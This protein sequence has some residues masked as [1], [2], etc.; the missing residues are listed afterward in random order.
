ME[1]MNRKYRKTIVAGNWK[2]YKT[3][4]ETREFAEAL[5]SM[6]PRAKRCSIVLCVPHVNIP[7]AMKV[8]KDSRV[9]VAAQNLVSERGLSDTF[10]LFKR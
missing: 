5:K 3:A 2:M 10:G 4:S 1:L 8:L 7:A 6:L 9:A